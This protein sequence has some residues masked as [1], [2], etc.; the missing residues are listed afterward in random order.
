MMRESIDYALEHHAEA[1]EYALQFARDMDPRL[2][3][4]FVGMYV[5]HY[6]ADAGEEIPK[7]VQILLDKG[8]EAGVIPT[9][10][11]AEFIR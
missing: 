1:L 5:N 9:R 10:V 7:A 6:T 4:K 8:F 3:E 2:A 11:Q